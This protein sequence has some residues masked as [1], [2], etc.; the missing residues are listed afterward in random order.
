M[1]QRK[2]VQLQ[3]Q[4][5]TTMGPV[6]LEI[7]KGLKMETQEPLW[8]GRHERR[9]TVKNQGPEEPTD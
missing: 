5:G 7:L 2:G 6:D 4:K 3:A 9:Q 8:S 1:R